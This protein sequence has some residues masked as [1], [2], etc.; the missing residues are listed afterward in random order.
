MDAQ[1]HSDA[2]AA[3]RSF[4]RRCVT[5]ALKVAGLGA[6]A[7]LSMAALN[8]ATASAD[9]LSDLLG[10]VT[11]TVQ[12]V[13]SATAGVTD[14]VNQALAPPP[15]PAAQPPAPAPA[16]PSPIVETVVAPIVQTV[17]VPVVDT[18]VAPVT[19]T[20]VA[21]IVDAV[22]QT[23]APITQTIVDS[24]VVSPVLDAAAG[25][26]T[27]VVNP[28]L[29]PVLGALHPVLGPVLA[30]IVGPVLGPVLG[31]IVGPVLGAVNPILG[32]VVGPIL[33]GVSGLATV[34]R[35]PVPDLPRA[36]QW[37]ASMASPVGAAGEAVLGGMTSAAA[38]ISSA[39]PSPL[40]MGVGGL[41]VAGMLTV[42]S[43][44]A[45]SALGGPGGQRRTPVP[46]SPSS[47]PTGA[48]TSGGDG[49]STS[50]GAL[51]AAGADA[52]L[53]RLGTQSSHDDALPASVVLRYLSFPG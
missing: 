21:P 40:T 49:P 37:I 30:P 5:L 2:T 10:S 25:L 23:A 34:P 24:P 33:D 51:S 32:P 14:S 50:P 52:T 48:T 38:A 6:G 53:R 17:V 11:S 35:L 3:P 12:Q 22:A 16:A 31:P 20:V 28:V 46:A 29:G 1:Q 39:V 42:L 15:G 8:A 19:D 9:P 43:A 26:L 4:G 18:V 27:P 7:W 44:A 41:G 36:G 45:G 13:E 47:A